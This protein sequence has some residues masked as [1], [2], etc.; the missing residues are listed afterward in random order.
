MMTESFAFLLASL[1]LREFV[2][3]SRPWLGILILGVT[4]LVKP[5]FLPVFLLSL[6]TLRLE[7]KSVA[8]IGFI[9]ILF[10]VQLSLT[11]RLDGQARLSSAGG[12]NF[13]QRFY[14]A[15]VGQV[16]GLGF[17]FLQGRTREIGPD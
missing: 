2:L 9:A 7:W 16:E 4:I 8:V 1:A 11:A 15:V 12:I 13:A 10:S 3:S 5:I 17:V 14:P 6:M